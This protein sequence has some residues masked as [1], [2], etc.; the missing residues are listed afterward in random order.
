M[1]G[2]RMPAR[3]RASTP[4]AAGGQPGLTRDVPMRSTFGQTAKRIGPKGEIAGIAYGFGKGAS[5]ETLE[6]VFLSHELSLGKFYGRESSQFYLLPP[7]STQ[8]QPGRYFSGCRLSQESLRL[9]DLI[10]P[11]THSTGV[12]GGRDRQTDGRRARSRRQAGRLAC[13]QARV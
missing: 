13:R 8:V 9:G 10:R 5:R 3:A 7:G 12:R 2:A 4:S 6:K 1:R 11:T